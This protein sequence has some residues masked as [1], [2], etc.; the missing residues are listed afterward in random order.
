MR[1]V[2]GL[3]ISPSMVVIVKSM[4]GVLG[5]EVGVG[6]SKSSSTGE[7]QTM[8]RVGALLLLLLLLLLLGVEGV[9]ATGV[10]GTSRSPN[11]HCRGWSERVEPG[12]T[13]PTTVPP[14][15]TIPVMLGVA[16][17]SKGR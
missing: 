7:R 16:K 14:P 15:L 10:A 11:L 5:G 2:E 1:G 17:G 13:T 6:S 12:S 9:E 3:R 4:V 8:L